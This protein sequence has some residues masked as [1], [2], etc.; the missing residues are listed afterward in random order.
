M[1][2]H[3]EENSSSKSA[4]MGSHSARRFKM[5]WTKRLRKKFLEA[6]EKLGVDNAAPK[7]ILELMKVNGLTRDHVSSYLQK[8]RFLLKKLAN[9]NYGVQT[10]SK[11]SLLECSMAN[12]A[13]WNN[14]S[15]MLNHDQMNWPSYSGMHTT[16]PPIV[17]I[18]SSC[19]PS[20]EA[21]N[22]NTTISSELIHS[23]PL[24]NEG[25][26]M[27]EMAN[28]LDE[29]GNL[30][31]D[32]ISM[33]VVNSLKSSNSGFVPNLDDFLYDYGGCTTDVYPYNNIEMGS[34]SGV[35][36]NTELPMS[37]NQENPI[38]I[39]NFSNSSFVE[40]SKCFV[41]NYSCQ[42]EF[43]EMGSLYDSNSNGNLENG[44]GEDDLLL[45]EADMA[46]LLAY[47]DY[48]GEC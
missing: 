24:P 34:S 33:G 47:A 17:N 20:L 28:R 3:E 14:S 25:Y 27:Q 26:S 19:F 30:I 2:D 32:T 46:S 29:Q 8:H 31:Y 4:S 41:R 6:V 10:A 23:G 37:W 5:V 16:N 36:M 48:N 40:N 1:S 7:K 38:N 18:S 39:A 42:S 11:S 13:F 22:L 12:D 45:T 15:L 44:I 35:N 43:V 21:S 9:E